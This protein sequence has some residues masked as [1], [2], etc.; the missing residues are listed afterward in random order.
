MSPFYAKLRPKSDDFAKWRYKQRR[1]WIERRKKG[2]EKK[3]KKNEKKRKKIKRKTKK[4][5]YFNCTHTVT[6]NEGFNT[7]FFGEHCP[8]VYLI[9]V[10]LEM[11]TNE[12]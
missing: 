10:I 7:S 11:K 4:K 8:T 3:R 2:G 1:E 12:M 9:L 6:F 5:E